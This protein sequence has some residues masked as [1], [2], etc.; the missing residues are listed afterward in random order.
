[1]RV[2][3]WLQERK[4]GTRQ[5][6]QAWELTA[7]SRKVGGESP[8]LAGEFFESV[9]TLSKKL[10]LLSI[11]HRERDLRTRYTLEHKFFF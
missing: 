5:I 6:V 7:E 11:Y 8:Q 9:V 1:M 3:F 10:P 2:E 4:T